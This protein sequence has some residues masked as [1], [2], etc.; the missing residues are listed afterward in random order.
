MKE[1]GICILLC[2]SERRD[3]TWMGDALCVVVTINPAPPLNR[4]CCCRLGTVVVP[5]PDVVPPLCRH[6]SLACCSDSSFEIPSSEV[7]FGGVVVVVLIGV[8]D[9]FS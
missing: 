3:E 5:P 9:P 1:S 6:Y 2:T 4:V 7:S 8:E